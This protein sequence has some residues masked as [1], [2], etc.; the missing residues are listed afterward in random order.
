MNRSAA[1]LLALTLAAAPLRADVIHTSDGSRLVGTIETIADGKLVILTEIAGRLE[2]DAAKV[3][4]IDTDGPVNVQFDTGD[5][6]IGTLEVF[7]DRDETVMRTGLGDIVI[8]GRTITSLWPKGEESPEVIAL[9]KQAEESL[10][11]LR[12]KWAA[13]LEAGGTLTEGNTKTLDGRGRLDIARKTSED[14]LTFFLAA[15]YSERDDARTKNEYRGGVRYEASRT[16]RTYWYTRIELEFDEFE[17]LD[18]RSTASVGE[19]YYWIREPD[20]ELKTSFG[21]G[22]RHEAFNLGRTTDAAVFDFALDYRIDL[23]P[24]AQFVH[25]GTYSPDIEETNDYRLDFDTA[26]VFPFQNEDLKLKIGVRNEYNSRP[27]RGI[28][29]LDSTYYANIVLKLK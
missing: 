1:I 4:A 15:D 20:R 12:P 8:T 29:R 13:T 25:S 17:D 23:A 19:G 16:E 9:K 7:A 24:W 2:I 22:Y 18:L 3:T 26:L 14:L 10:E 28:D 27:A 11:A 5:R 6:L 21:L